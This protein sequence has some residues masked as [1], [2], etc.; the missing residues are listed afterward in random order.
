MSG[1]GGLGG[2]GGTASIAGGAIILP[3]TG[4]H[5]ILTIVAFTCIAIGSAILLTTI[6]GWVAKKVYTKV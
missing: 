2:G 4:G 5:I 6:G 3:Y 1:S